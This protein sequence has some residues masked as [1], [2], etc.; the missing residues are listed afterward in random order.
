MRAARLAISASLML[1]LVVVAASQNDPTAAYA[2][3]VQTTLT[4]MARQ[5]IIAR[6]QLLKAGNFWLELVALYDVATFRKSRFFP[7]TESQ[8]SPNRLL[9]PS[10]RQSFL[11]SQKT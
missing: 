4:E 7:V 9:P 2:Q 10:N 3:R 5:T 6:P 8:V 11:R 1:A